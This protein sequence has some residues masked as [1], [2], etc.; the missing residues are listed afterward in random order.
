MSDA[1]RSQLAQ[2]ARDL[3]GRGLTTSTGGNLSH[4]LGFP[5]AHSPEV[6]GFLVSGTNTSFARQQPQD[7]AECD[8]HGGSQ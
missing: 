7:F 6:Q 8:L 3:A 4:R 1:L 2:A 5:E